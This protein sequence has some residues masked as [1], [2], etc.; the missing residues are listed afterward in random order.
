MR[1]I[2]LFVLTILVLTTHV[3]AYSDVLSKDWE[4]STIEELKEAQ[5]AIEAKIQELKDAQAELEKKQQ[6]EL[7][8][9][10]GEEKLALLH[11]HGIEYVSISSD[12]FKKSR[13]KYLGSWIYS[14]FK[15]RDKAYKNEINLVIFSK[16][17]SSS[18]DYTAEFE[19]ESELVDLKRGDIIAIVGRH[20][21]TGGLL[22]APGLSDCHLIAVGEK[23]VAIQNQIS[24]KDTTAIP[25]PT[26]NPTPEATAA[27]SKNVSFSFVQKTAETPEPKPTLT[28]DE[29]QK[30]FGNE[31]VYK[32]ISEYNAISKYPLHDIERGNIRTK[33]FGYSNDCWIEML[34]AT[35]AASGDFNITINGGNKKESIQKMFTV[36]PTMIS[37]LNKSLSEEK[38]QD[39]L[40]TIKASKYKTEIEIGYS[41]IVEY[42]PSV[43]LS[44]GYSDA[45]IDI[46]CRYYK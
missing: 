28:K 18:T 29:I 43:K 14:V 44:Y 15:V 16:G 11:E 46:R 38:I 24:S 45:R 36:F 21:S 3:I 41:I 33:Y 12:E 2:I 5:I 17:A 22:T 23:A 6:E 37:V 31:L 4:S 42:F 25:S 7:L 40:K 20:S 34:D 32:F 9:A 35:E 26:I 1:K 10:H 8:S 27:P 30:S 39:A 19:N 13:N